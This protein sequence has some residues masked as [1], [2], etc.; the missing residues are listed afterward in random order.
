MKYQK[1]GVKSDI[2][3]SFMSLILYCTMIER[4]HVDIHLIKGGHSDALVL[5]FPALN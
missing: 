3:M 2:R 4:Q 1:V 5:K